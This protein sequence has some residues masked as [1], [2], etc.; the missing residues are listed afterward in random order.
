MYVNVSDIFHSPAEVTILID[1]Q[2]IPSL[3]SVSLFKLSP[4][5]F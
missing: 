3:T 1:A 2:I 5:S 4:Q